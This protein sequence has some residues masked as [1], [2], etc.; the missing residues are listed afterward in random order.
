MKNFK[1]FL[2]KGH[3]YF[4]AAESRDHS[5]ISHGPWKVKSEVWRAKNWPEVWPKIRCWAPK[6]DRRLRRERH[7]H[8]PLR[9]ASQHKASQV[10]LADINPTQSIVPTRSIL[11][12]CEISCSSPFLKQKN[13]S[14]Q[15]FV[16]SMLGSDS[17]SRLFDSTIK[18]HFCCRI[19]VFFNLDY[20]FLFIHFYISRTNF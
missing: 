18:G 5:H 11:R 15:K 16:L 4:D 3:P 10:E 19:A 14:A 7:H 17:N 8:P 12:T 9:S 1:I 20:I 2:K 13:A 6:T